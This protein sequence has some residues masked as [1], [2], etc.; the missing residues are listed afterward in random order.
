M[1]ARQNTITFFVGLISG[2]AFAPTFL[3]PGL[4][5][6][7]A[8]L[9][10]QTKTAISLK[11]SLATGYIFGFGHF[12]AGIYWISIGVSVYIEEFWWVLPFA[13]LGLPLVLAC[14]IALSCAFSW[15]CRSYLYYPFFFSII[16]V[17]FEW[18]R[19][20]IFTGFPWNLAGY[21]LSFSHILI[22]SASIFGVYGLSFIV[23]YVSSMFAHSDARELK[24]SSINAVII[25]AIIIAY[26]SWRLS[27]NP[28]IF[29]DINIRL[30]QPSI[31]QTSKW[32]PNEFLNDLDRLITLSSAPG[33]PD[34]IIWSEA[35]LTIPYDHP[36]I[37]SKLSHM[38]QRTN[39]VL[40]TGGVADNGEPQPDLRIYSAMQGISKNGI[41][42]EYYKNHLVPFGEYV[43]L[44]EILLIKKLTP[45]LMDYSKGDNKLV[46]IQKFNIRIRPLICYESIFP[47]LVRTSN[48]AA[49]VII[50]ITN[51]SWYGR[52]SG[53]Y[54]HLHSSIMRSVENGLPMTRVANSGISVVVDPLG[55]I[56][57]DLKL[58]NIGILDEKL[59]KKLNTPTLYSQVGDAMAII[60]TIIAL[61]FHILIRL[62]TKKLF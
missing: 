9:C 6:G 53:P 22:Q 54:Q 50:N 1:I 51:D 59:P 62:L 8:Y 35:A 49:D 40:I 45:G 21:S 26:G 31:A 61:I 20:W 23:V 60:L 14:F 37:K 5:L 17:F 3:L 2:L 27:A 11:Q 16:W 39:A 10:Y 7:I 58:N 15:Y 57:K 30:V 33:N 18:V 47:A 43:P 56:I 13:L 32:D 46:Y 44:K 24:I 4:L 12:L 48:T 34:L 25:T 29:S 36:I 55:R 42:F 38:L 19:S 28:T 52:S 41:L